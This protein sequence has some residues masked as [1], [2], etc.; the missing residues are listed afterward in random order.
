MKATTLWQPYASLVA[1]GHKT[2]ET[3]GWALPAN[4]SPG[5]LAKQGR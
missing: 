3:R 2:V 5:K 4:L 1:D